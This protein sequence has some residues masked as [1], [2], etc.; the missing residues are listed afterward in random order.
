MLFNSRN[1]VDPKYPPATVPV[2]APP[3]WPVGY[4]FF[5]CEN[6]W[7]MSHDVEFIFVVS[8]EKA[9]IGALPTIPLARICAL[10]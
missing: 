8:T 6:S 4:G 1:L 5:T 3:A 7:L 10:P 2:A 9:S